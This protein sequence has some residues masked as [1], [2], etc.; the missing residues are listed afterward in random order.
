MLLNGSSLSGRYAG[1]QDHSACHYE[2]RPGIGKAR[3]LDITFTAV[4][5]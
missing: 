4:V 2:I 1:T 3:G 5:P